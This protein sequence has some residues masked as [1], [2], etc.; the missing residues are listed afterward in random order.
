MLEGKEQIVGLNCEGKRSRWIPDCFERR[1]RLWDQ[2]VREGT[3]SGVGLWD[4]T[5]CGVGL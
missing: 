3:T 2:A 4:R 1:S 5:G